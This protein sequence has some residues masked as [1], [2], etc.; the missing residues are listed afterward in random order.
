MKEVVRKEILNILTQAVEVLEK[1]ELK[2]TEELKELSEQAIEKVAAY[3]DLDLISITVLI[4]SLYKVVAVMTQDDYQGGLKH[5]AAAKDNLQQNNFGRYNTQIRSLYNLVRKSNAKVK[6]HLQDVMNAAKIKKGTSLFE[7]GLSIGQA[8][9]LMG[10]SNWDLQSYL[11]KTVAF[12]RHQE[13][14]PAKK[15]M[16]KAF[17]LFSI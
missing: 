11:G 6:E 5:L 17:N 3:K 14:I 15:R 8:A 1:K 10:L 12:E 2:D 16:L 9:G 13:L 7:H 4:Y